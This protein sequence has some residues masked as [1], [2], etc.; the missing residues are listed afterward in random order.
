MATLITK[1]F[2]KSLL[3]L[4]EDLE[5]FE[6]ITQGGETLVLDGFQAVLEYIRRQVEG[7]VIMR[8]DHDKALSRI[9]YLVLTVLKVPFILLW[10]FLPTETLCLLR[11]AFGD[12][13]IGNIEPESDATDCWVR[14][15][16]EGNFPNQNM[17]IA[18]RIVRRERDFDGLV[19]FVE[20]EYPLLQYHAQAGKDDMLRT[21]LVRPTWATAHLQCNRKL[22]QLRQRIT[23]ALHDIRVAN[24]LVEVTEIVDFEREFVTEGVTVQD[25][26]Q[27][28]LMQ[29]VNIDVGID[30]ISLSLGVR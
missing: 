10:T 9:E 27:P 2:T 28:F 15:G 5:G 22:V 4:L 30:R 23:S 12:L 25:C 29:S 18:L 19:S 17:G 26:I 14:V 3:F 11:G 1:G 13:V 6:S 7:V 20:A 16:A 21:K 24:E 8:T